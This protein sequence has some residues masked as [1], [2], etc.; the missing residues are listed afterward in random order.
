M[1]T[2]EKTNNI[3]NKIHS[4]GKKAGL[5]IKP[6]TSYEEIK[7]SGFDIIENAKWLENF[8]IEL[9]KKALGEE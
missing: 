4:L 6:K 1:A 8:Y 7:E 3:I 5:S 2:K 9:Y